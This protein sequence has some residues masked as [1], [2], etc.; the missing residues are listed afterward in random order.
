MN[1]RSTISKQRTIIHL[2]TVVIIAGF[3][4]AASIVSEL[5]AEIEELEEV[6]E[7]NESLRDRIAEL[8]AENEWLKNRNE[9]LEELE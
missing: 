1:D 7:I 8:T 6:Y 3:L 9:V 4:T 5:S 2:L